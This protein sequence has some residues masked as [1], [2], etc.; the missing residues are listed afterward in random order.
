M[1]IEHKIFAYPAPGCRAIARGSSRPPD[2]STAGANPVKSETDMVS[3]P[4]NFLPF[5][6]KCVERV[7]VFCSLA[8]LC[9]LLLSILN[10]NWH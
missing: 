7:K 5:E 9:I 10:T 8:L 6:I 3:V 2:M 1:N 4:K